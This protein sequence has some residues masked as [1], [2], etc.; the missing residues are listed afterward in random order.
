LVE[1]LAR[2]DEVIRFIRDAAG[3]EIGRGELAM[4]AEQERDGHS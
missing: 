2:S 3:R 4:L 1:G